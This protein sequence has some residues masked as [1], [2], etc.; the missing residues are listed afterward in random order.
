M[1]V[2]E[3]SVSTAQ[4]LDAYF[5]RTITYHHANDAIF[6]EASVDFNTQLAK[7]SIIIMDQENRGLA[8]IALS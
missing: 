1:F 7:S 2:D 4:S 6:G 5:R 3:L 8:S